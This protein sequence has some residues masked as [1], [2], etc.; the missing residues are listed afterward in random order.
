VLDFGIAKVMAD[1]ATLGGATQSIGTP[2]YMAPE[3]LNPHA[4][5]TGAADRYALAMVAY[6]LLV[7]APYWG[8]EARG[9]NVLAMAM[10]TVYGPREPASARA[11]RRGMT[12]S[13]SFDAWFARAAHV[14]PGQRFGSCV[15]MIA[16][17]AEALAQ[18]A[19]SRGALMSM[20]GVVEMSQSAP[21][22]DGPGG[23]T[24]AALFPTPGGMG[25]VT[26][27]FAGSAPLVPT[28]GPGT[29]ATRPGASSSRGTTAVL[30]AAGGVALLAL[31]GVGV[32]VVA[33]G[34]RAAAGGEASDAAAE[35]ALTA[36]AAPEAPAVPVVT[37]ASGAPPVTASSASAASASAAS[38]SAAS[39]SA[40]PRA[41][42]VTTTAPAPTVTATAAP[43]AKA[44]APDA[45]RKKMWGRD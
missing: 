28:T 4:R 22:F 2:T 39:A 19:P 10:V 40:V 29:T 13:P 16:A 15:E 3:Q 34:H 41:E 23:P 25:P 1:S 38:A 42:P 36:S 26:P 45:K 33:G 37:A 32:L 17:L 31:L 8:E 12:L 11:A 5:L 7:G 30:A 6:T 35:P 18:P 20:S 21:R 27:A 24:P 14:D 43:T 44:A 9:G